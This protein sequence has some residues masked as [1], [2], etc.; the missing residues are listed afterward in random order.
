MRKEIFASLV[1]AAGTVVSD[2]HGEARIER[3][4]TLNGGRPCQYAGIVEPLPAMKME[5]CT[6]CGCPFAT[7]PKM[8]TIAG[9]TITCPHPA[10]NQWAEIDEKF[11]NNKRTEQ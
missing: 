5:G 4:K 7:K 9:K 1:K 3:C 2:E 8:K 11:L 6:L 10:G